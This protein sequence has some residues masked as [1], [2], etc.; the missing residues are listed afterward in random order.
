VKRKPIHPLLRA[1]HRG[2]HRLHLRS[3]ETYQPVV[4]HGR[5]DGGARDCEV[6]WLAVRRTLD[7][8]KCRS[9]VDLGCSEGYYVLQ[10]ARFGLGFCVGVDFDLRR[11]WTGQ[12]QVVLEDI[13]NAAFLVAEIEPGLIDAM[14]PRLSER[15]LAD[16][17]NQMFIYDGER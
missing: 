10:A 6:R 5:E 11:I 1:V 7:T 12:N 3:Y 4:R 9:M 13:P 2:A 16:F 15:I 17:V 8:W 14:P